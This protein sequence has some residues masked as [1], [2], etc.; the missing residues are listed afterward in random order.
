MQGRRCHVHKSDDSP[1]RQCDAQF[2]PLMIES[3]AEQAE[4]GVSTN[5]R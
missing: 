3:V 1:D 2:L 5:P 4:G